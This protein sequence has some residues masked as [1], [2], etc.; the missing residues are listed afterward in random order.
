MIESIKFY[1]PI[2]TNSS[3]HLVLVIAHDKA[4]IYKVTTDSVSRRRFQ[5]TRHS[6]STLAFH[7]NIKRIRH[8]NQ[9]LFNPTDLLS[10]FRSKNIISRSGR[11]QFAIQHQQFLA[12]ASIKHGHFVLAGQMQHGA[13]NANKGSTRRGIGNIK[14]FARK[15]DQAFLDGKGTNVATEGLVATKAGIIRQGVLGIQSTRLATNQIANVVENV[16]EATISR[17]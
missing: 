16:K 8:G 6:K 15:T 7:I 4:S 13:S 10:T 11:Y 2:F 5:Q 1:D 17:I 12:T 14:I 9:F 3:Y